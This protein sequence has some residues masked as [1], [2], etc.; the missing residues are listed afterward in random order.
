MKSISS[1]AL[2]AS[3]VLISCSKSSSSEDNAPPPKEVSKEAL[4]GNI[5]YNL[6][7][8]A[9]Q[10]FSDDLL[11]LSKAWDLQ[12]RGDSQDS[13]ALHAA[14]QRTVESWQM[15]HILTYAPIGEDPHE[16]KLAVDSASS[17]RAIPFHITKAA[18]QVLEGEELTLKANQSGL[19][20]LEILIYR[21]EELTCHSRSRQSRM[22]FTRVDRT[23]T[24]LSQE[25]QQKSFCLLGQ[26]ILADLRQ[27]ASVLM[28]SWN[29]KTSQRPDQLSLAVQSSLTM[30]SESL[31][32]VDPLIKDLKLLRPLGLVEAC[33]SGKTCP[34]LVEYPYGKLSKEALMANLRGLRA[35]FDGRID[36]VSLANPD[37]PAV[38]FAD[39]LKLIGHKDLAANIAE[40]IDMALG[41]AEALDGSMYEAVSQLE[42][43]SCVEDS[44]GAPLCLVYGAV[45]E[46][47]DLIKG[48]FQLAMNVD[49]PKRAG[50]DND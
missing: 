20:A 40:K 25:E 30:A 36:E 37:I 24:G 43:G 46:L 33:P 41:Y 28:E 7:P 18:A 9:A 3:L 49:V 26:K 22:G 21:D 47:S 45:K 2:L 42:A 4:V 29:P 27:Q 39:Y 5:V 12:C 50:G 35:F 15:F 10:Q 44:A 23:W 31:L 19:D 17:T 34:C 1:M 14:F 16:W 11:A 13:S 6:V 48:E 38:G 8:G 32:A